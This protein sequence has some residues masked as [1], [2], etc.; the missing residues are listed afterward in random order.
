[1]SQTG[2]TPKSLGDQAEDRALAHLQR[3]GLRLGL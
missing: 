2:V 1:M 3:Q